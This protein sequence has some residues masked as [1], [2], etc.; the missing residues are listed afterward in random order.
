MNTFITTLIIIVLILFGLIGGFFAGKASKNIETVDN[1]SISL[2][3]VQDEM[4]VLQSNFSTLT[5]ELAKKTGITFQQSNF[6]LE[7]ALA[8]TDALIQ[9]G[10]LAKAALY[11]SNA[12][13]QSPDRFQTIEHYQQ[14]VLAYCQ[15][16]NQQGDYETVLN[17]LVDM[18][19]FLR[20]QAMEIKPQFIDKLEKILTEIADFR[21]TV[22]TASI[23][24][25]NEETLKFV[26]ELTNN[27]GQLLKQQPKL[28]IPNIT[29][30]LEKLKDNLLTLQSID[31]SI[32]QK[33]EL[34]T[35]NNITKQL[36]DKIASVEPQLAVIQK[37]S[38]VSEFV[39]QINTLFKK[40]KA[41]STESPLILYY[42]TLI[43][44]LLNQ[45]IL[46]APNTQEMQIQL[47]NFS[48]E[49][50]LVKENLAKTHSQAVWHDMDKLISTQLV[51]DKNSKAQDAIVKLV[52]LRQLFAEKANGLTSL[53]FL[54]KAKALRDQIENAIVDWQNKQVHKYNQF[55]IRRI[56]DL[57]DTYKNQLGVNTDEEIVYNATIELLGPIDTRYLSTAAM[58]GYN[59]VFGK[60][61]AELGDEQKISLSSEMTL[62]PKKLLAD[63]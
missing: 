28:D 41:E 20:I 13:A 23:T 58:T 47:V 51:V 31:T 54:E 62:K 9:Q 49:L 40:V 14:T 1:F 19:N 59:E 12:L 30:Y 39:Q 46:I 52:Q 16:L 48:K 22:E 37:Q 60:F 35:L 25:N 43:D 34:V 36:G 42:L 6:D 53:E 63:F 5:T 11:F 45:F 15:Q 21:Q 27:S 57:Y 8:K 2:H 50:E 44:S 56:K 33:N 29:E 55:A 61:Y 18:D 4:R 26:H 10:E 38:M 3:Q 32:F 24:R 17:I 7:A